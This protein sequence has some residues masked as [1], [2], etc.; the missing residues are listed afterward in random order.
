MEGRFKQ[1]LVASL[2]VKRQ[3]LVE[4]LAGLEE[5]FELRKQEHLADPS[6][7]LDQTGYEQGRKTLLDEITRVDRELVAATQRT[8]AAAIQPSNYHQLSAE[9][10][11]MVDKRLG[12]LD[13]EN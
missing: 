6:I 5:T 8:G 13:W 2:N 12:I 3:C 10:Q 11:W 9:E 1:A 4:G 7:E